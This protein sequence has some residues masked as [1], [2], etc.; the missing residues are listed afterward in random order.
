MLNILSFVQIYGLAIMGSNY[1]HY[2]SL[3]YSIKYV[4]HGAYFNKNTE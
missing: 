1:E 3:F 2:N 4:L